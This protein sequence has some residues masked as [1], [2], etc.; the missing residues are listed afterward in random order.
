MEND[1]NQIKQYAIDTFEA[2]AAAVRN[3]SNLLT[4]DFAKA[5]EAILKC[6]GKVVV[7]G[8]GKSGIIG[9]KIAATLAS[10]GTPSFFLHPGEAYHGDLGNDLFE[11]H[12][13]GDCQPPDRRTRSC[14]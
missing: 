13:V 11:R 2:E 5:V 14:G 1:K 6:T 3:L 8:M 12:R 10:T 9:K 7:T 4:D